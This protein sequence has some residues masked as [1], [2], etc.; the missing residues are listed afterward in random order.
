MNKLQI[1]ELKRKALLESESKS[2]ENKKV[3]AL[4]KN[5]TH[6]AKITTDEL[7][8]RHF[9]QIENFSIWGIFRNGEALNIDDNSCLSSRKEILKCQ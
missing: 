7:I 6:L 3:Y 1:A 2:N 5:G 8:V 9:V 4:I